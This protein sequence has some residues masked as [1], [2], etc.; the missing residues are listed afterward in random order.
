M[1]IIQIYTGR[2][3]MITKRLLSFLNFKG[4]KMLRSVYCSKLFITVQMCVHFVSVL[5]AQIT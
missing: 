1:Y 2:Y 3:L 4:K 5:L